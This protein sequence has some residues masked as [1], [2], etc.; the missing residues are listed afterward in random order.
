MSSAKTPIISSLLTNEKYQDDQ[1]I[2][3]YLTIAIF[4]P[5]IYIICFCILCY[6]HIQ[7]WEKDNKSKLGLYKF[8]FYISIVTIILY[9]LCI[10]WILFFKGK[11]RAKMT[12]LF[13]IIISI[14]FYFFLGQ[15]ISD[16][17]KLWGLQE[18]K[19]LSEFVFVS[20]WIQWMF[21]IPTFVLLIQKQS[22]TQTQK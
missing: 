6:V 19:R 10:I 5:L 7:K 11:E 16:D 15:I 14:V 8:A 18:Y 9:L 17:T 4:I 12:Y 2:N 3:I 20:S 21:Y 1:K 22:Q 13:I